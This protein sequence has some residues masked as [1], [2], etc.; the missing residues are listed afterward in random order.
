MFGLDLNP[1][2]KVGL[3]SV[4]VG[5][6]A[7]AGFA[8]LF[9]DRLAFPAPPTSYR[10]GPETIKF[11]YGEAGE[12]VTLQYLPQPQSRFLIV[13]HHGNG[14]DLGTI[15]DRLEILYKAGFAV[16]AWDY[17]GYGTSDGSAS[18]SSVITAAKA[19]LESI[20][21]RY[22]YSI[23]QTIQY[24]RSIGGGPALALASEYP[25]AGVILEGTFTSI[26]EVGLPVNILPWDIFNNL[27]RIPRIQCPVI[28]LHGTNDETVPFSHGKQLYDAA[29]NPKFF[30][31]F[32]GGRHN[33]L[34]DDFPQT[35]SDALNGFQ[36]HLT[37]QSQQ[38]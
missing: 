17:P 31:W 12:A 18:E 10:D 21:Q 33:N 20:P 16:L 9:A 11:T 34:V 22:G 37:Q 23:E 1:V 5:Y 3:I 26:F 7:L 35:Y 27:Q 28:V 13:Y 4:V 8:L 30:A 32:D 38:Q 19:L 24:G 36:Q 29:Q 25:V 15:Q 14:E 2:L 6:L